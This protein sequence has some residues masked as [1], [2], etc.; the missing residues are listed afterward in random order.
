VFISHDLAVVRAISDRVAVMKQG[1]IVEQGAV[2]DVFHDP[3][4]DYTVDL[5][6]A[7]AGRRTLAGAR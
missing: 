2:E 4:D 1:R 3:Q 6:A 5:L 7:I